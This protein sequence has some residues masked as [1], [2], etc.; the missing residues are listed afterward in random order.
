MES[1]VASVQWKGSDLCADVICGCGADW[2]VDA[3]MPFSGFIRCPSCLR[4]WE[5]PS[6]LPLRHATDEQVH[7]DTQVVWGRLDEDA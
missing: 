2:H 1:G 6:A 5:I 4:I 3:E 7:P